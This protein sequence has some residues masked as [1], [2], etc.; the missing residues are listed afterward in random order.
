MCVFTNKCENH[1]YESVCFGELRA[2]FPS[3]SVP[4]AS[5]TAA[6]Y[7]GCEDAVYSAQDI[8]LDCESSC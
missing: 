8:N 4:L 3:N 2:A 7:K 1:V 5:F 6:K